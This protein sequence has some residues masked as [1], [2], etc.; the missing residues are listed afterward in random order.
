MIV[1][2]IVVVVVFFL[3]KI[4]NLYMRVFYFVN[5]SMLLVFV[6]FIFLGFYFKSFY[7]GH[8]DVYPSLIIS[9]WWMKVLIFIVLPM[10]FIYLLFYGFTKIRKSK[11]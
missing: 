6:Y 1:F 11:T 5:V 10:N 3:R 9:R 7:M 4:T 2:F 8:L